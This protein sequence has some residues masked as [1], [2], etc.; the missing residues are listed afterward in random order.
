[1]RDRI[2]SHESEG[3]MTRLTQFGHGRLLDMSGASDSIS[4]DGAS[5]EMW[6]RIWG[7]ACIAMFSFLWGPAVIFSET[8][9]HPSVASEEA[10]SA[11]V[12]V[13]SREG[14]DDLLLA[15]FGFQSAT[16]S[17]I[18]IRTYLAETGA[19]VAEES[20]D[21][22]VQENGASGE[23]KRGR[24]FAG[25]IGVGA[26][27]QSRFLLRVYD[28]LTGKFLWEGQLNLTSQKEER[29][30]R[31]IATVT[32]LRSSVWKAGI[33][34]E[35]S[36]QV[37]LSLRA[38]D[39]Q[40][41]MLVWEDKFIPGATRMGRSERTGFRSVDRP[42]QIET[43]GHVFD[44][45][46]RT[47]DRSSGRLLWQDSFEDLNELEEREREGGRLLE[48]QTLPFRNGRGPAQAATIGP[49]ECDHDYDGRW[50]SLEWKVSAHCCWNLS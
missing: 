36:V 9:Y 13:V 26:D 48:P 10:I 20:Y 50:C 19:V 45:I 41:G 30:A 29:R 43:I 35:P 3:I 47:F 11:P 21:L 40:T 5:R 15:G 34:A 24:I 33:K 27:G 17:L 38:I 32:P 18:T 14:H 42:A 44:L 16:S 12:S 28:A 49:F 23:A 25:G 1:M 39:P 37:Y 4:T 31:P 6:G 46:V 8:L 7:W 2:A 22:T